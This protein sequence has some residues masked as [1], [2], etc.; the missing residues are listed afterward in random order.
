M[1]PRFPDPQWFL[2]LG[3]LMAAR[4]ELFRRIGY[5]ETRF[6]VRVLPDEDGGGP[7]DQNTEQNTGVAMAGYALTDAIALAPGE[8]VSFD[9][10]FA[11][12]AQRA[13]WRRMLEEIARN[14]R[15]ELR[16]TLNSLA[17]LGDELLARIRRPVARR[18]VLSFQSEPAGTFQSRRATARR[19]IFRQHSSTRSDMEPTVTRAEKSRREHK[20]LIFFL[21]ALEVL[22]AALLIV[23]LAID[24]D[25][26]RVAAYA[27]GMPVTFAL[28]GNIGLY[29]SWSDKK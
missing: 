3:G 16:H 9:P 29:L 26:L 19:L 5:V 21:V 12:C 1:A 15:P 24:N 23:G 18:Q 13:V 28:L 10:D 14:G 27:L 2:A 17:L 8:A 11:I 4:G 7:A 20:T 22:A 6:V 25:S